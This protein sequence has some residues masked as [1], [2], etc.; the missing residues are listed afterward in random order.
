MRSSSSSSWNRHA[1]R[2]GGRETARLDWACNWCDQNE[3]RFF[4]F[5]ARHRRVLSGLTEWR[6]PQSIHLERIEHWTEFFLSLS[7]RPKKKNG[8]TGE[9]RELFFNSF[10]WS[11]LA[12]T[13]WCSVK[14]PPFLCRVRNSSVFDS[15]L[16][17]E[18]LSPCTR[19]TAPP[20]VFTV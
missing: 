18:S 16:L 6:Y 9:Q 20:P 13:I 2:S 3:K 10:C 11:P 12:Q 15:P 1:N 14:G 17:F 4:Q 8:G 19:F 5:A 7:S